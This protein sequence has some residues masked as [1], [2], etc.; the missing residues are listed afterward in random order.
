MSFL[1]TMIYAR[2]HLLHW[3]IQPAHM[4]DGACPASAADIS[5]CCI[6][7][8]TAIY[9]LY[10]SR[11]QKG[12]AHV[13]TI[14]ETETVEQAKPPPMVELVRS[15]PN[16]EGGGGGGHTTSFCPLGKSSHPPLQLGSL[17]CSRLL[18]H[19]PPPPRGIEKDWSNSLIARFRH[20]TRCLI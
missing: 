20:D 2:P 9:F 8:A 7:R 17:A 12:A 15:V 14:M 3:L 1:L 13:K 16:K 11:S 19:I 5:L 4:Y 18:N 6:Q 10:I